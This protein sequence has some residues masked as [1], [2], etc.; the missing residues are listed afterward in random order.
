MNSLTN[1]HKWTCNFQRYF[2]KGD[3][4]LW[5]NEGKV[6]EIIYRRRMNA[7]IRSPKF[8]WNIE[9]GGL[10][11]KEFCVFEED[12]GEEIALIE[13]KFFS[14][15][16]LIFRDK[17]DKRLF[18]RKRWS[19]FWKNTFVW[20]DDRG[21]VYTRFNLPINPFSRQI[22]IDIDFD[23]LDEKDAVFLAGTGIYLMRFVR[24]K[25]R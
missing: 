4:E 25:K 2:G 21:T 19:E 3:A 12:S 1:I 23:K 24:N 22:E 14:N 6:V 7:L 8:A 18:L 17:P 11:T 10:L 16:E 20:E 13:R 15:F 9:F 5:N